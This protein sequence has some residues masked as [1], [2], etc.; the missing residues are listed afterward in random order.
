MTAIA[1]TVAGFLTGLFVALWITH[2]R[3]VHWLLVG[4]RSGEAMHDRSF[5]GWNQTPTP[6]RRLRI[7]DWH[8]VNR[9]FTRTREQQRAP[10]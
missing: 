7:V 3:R 4:Q 1:G 6:R 8:L 2:H 10:R 5:A 9:Q